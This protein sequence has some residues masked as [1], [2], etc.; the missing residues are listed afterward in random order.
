[1]P[2]LL[3]PHGLTRPWSAS[4]RTRCSARDGPTIAGRQRAAISCRKWPR[5][6][7]GT[8]ARARRRRTGRSGRRACNRGL[9]TGRRYCPRSNRTCGLSRGRR[10]TNGNCC[11]RSRGRRF[12]CRRRRYGGSRGRFG[13]N[14]CNRGSGCHWC[15]WLRDRR[16]WDN[17]F[18]SRC[19][20]CSWRCRG[21]SRPH[22]RGLCGGIFRFLVRFDSGFRLSFGFRLAEKIFADFFCHIDWNRTR[23]RLLFRDAIPRQ[24][25]NDGFGLDLEF[26]GQLVDSDLVCVSHAS[27]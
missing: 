24:Q 18:R 7:A 25:V 16:Y 22:S 11:G 27:F 5:G 9:C 12:R 14:R 20:T 21:R 1:L 13:G 19:N 4:P 23:V 2:G 6:S 8:Y 26:T 3:R 17:R 15:S 10:R